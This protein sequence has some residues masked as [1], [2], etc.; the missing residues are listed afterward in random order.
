MIDSRTLITGI[1]PARGRSSMA[2][3]SLECWWRQ[4]WPDKEIVILDDID[5]PAFPEFLAASAEMAGFGAQSATV[6]LSAPRTTDSGAQAVKGYNRPGLRYFA[7]PNRI[8]IGEKRNLACSLAHGSFVAH[9]DS[10]DWSAAGRLQDQMMHM[11]SDV[12]LVGYHS[13]LWTNGS[14]WWRYDG[15][16]FDGAYGALGTS[17]LYRK[18]WWETH[19]FPRGPVKRVDAEDN[20]FVQAAMNAGVFVGVPAREMMVARIHP[21][22]TSPKSTGGMRWHPVQDA[23]TLQRYRA[24]LG[25]L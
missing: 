19:H 12:S 16:L 23:S 11:R 25:E 13:M 18:P 7:L 3:A 1:M 4:T 24:M 22:N 8:T 20:P 9:V 21:D 14:S 5:L 17:F 6:G 15:P 2:A 10:D